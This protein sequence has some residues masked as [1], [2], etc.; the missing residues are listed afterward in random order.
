[1]SFLDF[2][3]NSLYLETLGTF[4]NLLMDVSW[5]TSLN[6][7]ANKMNSSQNQV[8]PQPIQQQHIANGGTH[9]GESPEVYT[10]QE[11]TTLFA[12]AQKSKAWASL[13]ASPQATYLIL[14][15]ALL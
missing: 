4:L 9:L 1:M 6:K 7:P 10:G 2:G 15:Q 8:R 3:Y 12:R 13:I 14:S 11:T 5:V